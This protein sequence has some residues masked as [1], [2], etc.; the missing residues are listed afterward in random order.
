M[1]KI[2]QPPAFRGPAK[3][4]S[5]VDDMRKEMQALIDKYGLAK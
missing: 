2:G 5:A 3:M 1:K 4:K